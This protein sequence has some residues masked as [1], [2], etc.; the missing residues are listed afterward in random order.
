MRETKFETEQMHKALSNLEH[1]KNKLATEVAPNRE[2]YEN[3]ERELLELSTWIA[4]QGFI[5]LNDK[6]AL[7]NRYITEYQKYKLSKEKCS[8]A[9]AEKETEFLLKD[10][11]QKLKT[12]E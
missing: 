9:E 1:L 12:N 5:L 7:D 11:F 8:N 4:T 10:E 6:L 3:W 2:L